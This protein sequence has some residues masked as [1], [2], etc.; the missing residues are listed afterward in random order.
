MLLP[1]TK[2]VEVSFRRAVLQ[3]KRHT[4]D[5]IR[6][7]IGVLYSAMDSLRHV[8]LDLTTLSALHKPEL[9]DI[10]TPWSNKA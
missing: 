5:A 9:V 4:P 10:S 2:R 8:E 7:D 3:L 6:T 1:C